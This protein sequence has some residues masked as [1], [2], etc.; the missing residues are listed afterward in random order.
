MLT[1]FH[2]LWLRLLRT[3]ESFANLNVDIKEL[4][5]VSQIVTMLHNINTELEKKLNPQ[6]STQMDQYERKFESH[7]ENS[8]CDCASL[9]TK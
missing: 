3:K 4:S 8:K 9:W 6:T 5:K 2:Y 7:L 1:F